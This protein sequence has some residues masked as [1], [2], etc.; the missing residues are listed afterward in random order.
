MADVNGD[1]WLDIYVSYSEKEI[2]IV[3]ETNFGSIRK[4][5]HSKIRLRN[6]D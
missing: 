1:G 2:P 4:T 6:L 3:G 5:S